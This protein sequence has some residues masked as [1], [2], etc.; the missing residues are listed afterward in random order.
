MFHGYYEGL[1]ASELAM[2][3]VDQPSHRLRTADR[4]RA[5]SVGSHEAA[6][7]DQHLGDVA[8]LIEWERRAD[9]RKLEYD[10]SFFK[11]AVDQLFAR[12]NTTEA[13]T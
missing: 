13:G 1:T 7:Y 12:P 4:L 8:G 10:G 9:K 3:E 5:Q 6:D 2:V 11:D